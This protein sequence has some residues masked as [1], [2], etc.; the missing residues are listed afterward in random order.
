VQLALQ[1]GFPA[2]G[3]LPPAARTLIHTVTSIRR[4]IGFLG[5]LKTICV[6]SCANSTECPAK[7]PI[8]VKA[9]KPSADKNAAPAAS[10]GKGM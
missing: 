8:C 4:I 2:A 7:I 9:K 10:T 3:W 5:P 6:H 1:T